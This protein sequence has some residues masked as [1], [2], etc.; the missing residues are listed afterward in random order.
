MEG[1]HD[2]SAPQRQKLSGEGEGLLCH[3]LWPTEPAWGAGSGRQRTG[4]V[5]WQEAGWGSGC[6]IKAPLEHLLPAGSEADSKKVKGQSATFGY[7]GRALNNS[8]GDH[9]HHSLWNSASY[10]CV[11]WW[12]W[13]RREAGD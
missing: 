4:D 11:T 6:W 1:A 3:N 10:S 13:G 2:K 8:E 9:S 5:E 7:T 12:P